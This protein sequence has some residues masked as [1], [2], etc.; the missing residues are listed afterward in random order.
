MKRLV[1]L[2]TALLIVP[3]TASARQIQGS[4]FALAKERNFAHFI[5]EPHGITD[6]CTSKKLDFDVVRVGGGYYVERAE[7]V[8]RSQFIA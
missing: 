7:A 8:M 3:N 2:I 5:I 1:H 6:T 4:V